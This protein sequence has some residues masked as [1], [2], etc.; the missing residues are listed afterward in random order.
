MTNEQILKKAIEKAVE[1]GWKIDK[2]DEELLRD[3]EL[4]DD[5]TIRLFYSQY[6]HIYKFL[7]SHDFA[8][9]LLGNKKIVIGQKAVKKNHIIQYL[10][11]IRIAWQYHL[12]QMVL[13][14]E[15]LKYIEEFLNEK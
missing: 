13:E 4:L 2:E 9:A 15:P 8:K 1:N 3:G 6:E 14:K 5:G 10:P 7:F 11:I 12:Q